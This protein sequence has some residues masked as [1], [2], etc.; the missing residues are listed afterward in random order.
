VFGNFVGTGIL[1]ILLGLGTGAFNPATYITL[2]NT[3][4]YSNAQSAQDYYIAVGDFNGDGNPDIVS[5]N[6][7]SNSMSVMLGTG[8]GSFS[9]GVNFPTG[10]EPHGPVCADFNGDG[11]LDIASPNSRT[12]TITVSLNNGT[13]GFP[14]PLIIVSAPTGTT[15]L[16]IAVG[17]FNS[18][19]HIDLVATYGNGISLLLGSGNGQFQTYTTFPAQQ[20]NAD[21]W[22]IAVGD[23]NL[24]GNLD[25]VATYNTANN[26]VE[27]FLGNGNGNFVTSSYSGFATP[28]NMA[29]GDINGDCKLDLVTSEPVTI[30]LGT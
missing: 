22:A 9:A 28:F 4:G 29:V 25:A 8:T 11:K 23:F 21:L 14:T 17:N 18:D 2:P 15:V 7:Q 12:N 30:I 20:A 24:D 19:S 13:G 26:A 27:L 1:T 10:Q 16:H 5:N 6:E 3:Q